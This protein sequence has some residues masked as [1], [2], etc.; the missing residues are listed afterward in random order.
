MDIFVPE[1][2]QIYF[3]NKVYPSLPSISSVP[4]IISSISCIP[5]VKI[6]SEVPVQVPK[7]FISRFT[8]LCAF[9]IDSNFHFQVLNC[10][11]HFHFLR[12][13]VCV[14]INYFKEFTLQKSYSRYVCVLVMLQYLGSIVIRLTSKNR[15]ELRGSQVD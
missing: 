11:I 1:F 14:F 9:F 15:D 8:S 3:L 6:A 5:L 13:F 2:L 12:L 4:K 10:F 7:L